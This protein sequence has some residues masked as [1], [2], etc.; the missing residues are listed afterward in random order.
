[1]YPQ[2]IA[3]VESHSMLA[4]KSFMAIAYIQRFLNPSKVGIMIFCAKE[5]AKIG[6]DDV[7]VFLKYAN[8]SLCNV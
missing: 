6:S 3:P 4:G 8:S 1:V 5:A 7:H 2:Q